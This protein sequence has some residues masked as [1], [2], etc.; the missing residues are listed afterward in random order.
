META[1]NWKSTPFISI[2]HCICLFTLA[3]TGWVGMWVPSLMALFSKVA[4]NL[5]FDVILNGGFCSRK[6]H[7]DK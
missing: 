5:D 2:M 7:A 3:I 6:R 4:G 1:R